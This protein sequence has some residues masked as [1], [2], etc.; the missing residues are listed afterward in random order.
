MFVTG[1]WYEPRPRLSFLTTRRW[2]IDMH[3]LI[4]PQEPIILLNQPVVKEYL[5][6]SLDGSLMSV[7][8]KHAGA[9]DSHKTPMELLTTNEKTP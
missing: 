5:D 4:N 6:R 7:Q 1:S 2:V 3:K 9:V 8:E